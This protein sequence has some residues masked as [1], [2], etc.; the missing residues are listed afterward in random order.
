MGDLLGASD[1]LLTVVIAAIVTIIVF[2]IAVSAIKALI[3][4]VPPN[5]ASIVTG[6]KRILSVGTEVGYR[7]VI[8]GRT[9]R[10]PIIEKVQW[11]SLETYPLEI[12]VNN[13]FSKGNI[14]LDIE[15]IANVKIASEPEA[16][17]NNAVE[18]LLEK[19]EAEIQS[20]AKDTLMGN[21]RG[22]LATL[23][24]E[25]VNEDRL[26]FAKALSEDAGEDLAALG[27]RLDVLKIQNVSDQRGY[28]AA[29]GRKK[30][31]EAVR[32]A[33]MA[34]AEAAA[35]TRRAQAEALRDAE[36]AEVQAEAATRAAQ[37]IAGQQAEIAEANA[38]ALTRQAQAE[39][40]QA[41][42]VTEATADID[43]AE[44]NNRLRVRRA[45]LAGE[46][47]TVER[48]TK[49]QAKQAEV[50]A[51]RALEEERV[52]KE[53]MRLK[54]DVI[55]PAEASKVAALAKAAGDAALILEEGRANAEAFKLLA[56]QVR[57]GGENAISL[58]LADRLPQMLST[59]VDAVSGM[60]IERLVV[61]DGGEGEGVSKAANQKVKGAIGT[62]EAV[63]AALGLDV[64]KILSNAVS[65]RLSPKTLDEVPLAEEIRP[66]QSSPGESV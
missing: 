59:A 39:A 33:E 44:A 12:S 60:Q 11:L 28:L 30:S 31:A 14:P 13:A 16:V 24:P 40:K 7:T 49:V 41:A 38:T 18:R 61:L 54:A 20:I 25:Q 34:E 6:R 50:Q 9:M 56:E 52:E 19:P 2:V 64:Q 62:I 8:G 45:E 32:D 48:T 43:I 58:F 4:I 22:V 1:G 36:I 46:A 5:S 10:V 37:A 55:E 15:A 42:E 65:S 3:V 26:G 51:L 29:I 17:F 66:V 35:E 23:T 47:E 57:S 27:L 53:K 21:L 63:S